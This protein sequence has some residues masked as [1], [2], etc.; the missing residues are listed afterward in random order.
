MWVVVVF[1]AGDVSAVPLSWIL[2]IDG[3]I[4]CFWPL[5]KHRDKIKKNCKPPE[6]PNEYWE[7]YEC[8]ILFNESKTVKFENPNFY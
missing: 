7:L 2:R 8:R 5:D 1:V 6:S 3:Q 4:L